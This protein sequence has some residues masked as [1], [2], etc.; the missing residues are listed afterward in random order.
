M[1]SKRILKM[2]KTKNLQILEKPVKPA[3]KK[4]KPAR[5]VFSKNGGFSEPCTKDL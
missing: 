5:Q 2:K 3:L 4:Q 1:Q